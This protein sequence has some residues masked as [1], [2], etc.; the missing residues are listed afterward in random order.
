MSL[1]L[2]THLVTVVYNSTCLALNK[3][4]VVLTVLMKTMQQ[5]QTA[6]FL[7]LSRIMSHHV[8][9]DNFNSLTEDKLCVAEF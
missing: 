5:A 8:D 7:P 9:T 4:L 1:V 3:S 2:G 6:A